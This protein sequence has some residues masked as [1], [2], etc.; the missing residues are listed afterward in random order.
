MDRVANFCFLKLLQFMDLLCRSLFLKV[1]FV[2]KLL[3]LFWYRL[4]CRHIYT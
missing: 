4:S 1:C 2:Y 3:L